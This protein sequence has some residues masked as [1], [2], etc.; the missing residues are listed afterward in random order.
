MI[1]EV[2][3]FPEELGAARVVAFQDLQAPVCGGVAVLEDPKV[4]GVWRY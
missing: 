4:P 1:V 3:E 2:V